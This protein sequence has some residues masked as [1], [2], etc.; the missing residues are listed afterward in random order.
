MCESTPIGSQ[1]MMGAA[2]SFTFFRVTVMLG[3]V[4]RQGMMSSCPSLMYRSLGMS[5]CIS[6]K[7]LSASAWGRNTSK[8]LTMSLDCGCRASPSS[9]AVCFLSRNLTFHESVSQ[10]SPV[11]QWDY[12]DTCHRDH[13]VQKL[14]KCN[15]G[16]RGRCCINF[17]YAKYPPKVPS[18]VFVTT[19]KTQ[20]LLLGRVGPETEISK[21]EG[22][23]I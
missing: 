6:M 17:S 14:Q 20:V 13:Q 15:E 9:T 1:A 5:L 2:L 23:I 3:D 8:E 22:I 10:T 19:G 18:R 16:G 7:G 4:T 12:P 21:P 11:L